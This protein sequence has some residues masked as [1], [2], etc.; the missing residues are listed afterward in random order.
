MSFLRND[1]INKQNDY[2]LREQILDEYIFSKP[3]SLIDNY[4]KCLVLNM[5]N[6]NKNYKNI[7]NNAELQQ[8]TIKE[9][10]K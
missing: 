4:N 10:Y 2:N 3:H 5:L 8:S 1:G 9:I 7:Y 6:K